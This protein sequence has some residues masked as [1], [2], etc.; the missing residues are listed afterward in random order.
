[1]LFR[2]S[3]IQETH[4][5]DL[6]YHMYVEEI[7]WCMRV[8]KAGW[9]IYCVPS[10]RIV[11]F[12]GQSTSQVRPEMIVALWRSRYIL[13]RKHYS[14]LYRW[15][16]TRVIQAGMRAKIRRLGRSVEE[17]KVDDSVARRLIGAYQ[18]VLAM[19]PWA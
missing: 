1:M 5:F 17:G 14:P 2:S 13:F 11:H 12:E 18:Q 9:G 3:A 6:D 15:L 8:K 7:D 10:A 16:A 19:G 4:G